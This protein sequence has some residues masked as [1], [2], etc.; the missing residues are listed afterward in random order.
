MRPTSVVVSKISKHSS[1]A[2]LLALLRAEGLEDAC[3]FIY[4]PVGFRDG[5]VCGY[6]FLNFISHEIA[7]A[8][9][10]A[11]DR[12]MPPVAEVGGE[13]LEVEWA[14]GNQG[15]ESLVNR[16]RNSPVLLP[17][18]PEEWQPLLFSEGRR[19]PFPAPTRNVKAVP[20]LQSKSLTGAE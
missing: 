13:P 4:L 9:F 12:Q 14:K 16:Y 2:A 5:L 18:V 17:G 3:D 1:R 15:L 19:V 6:A 8:A 20:H 10:E 11:L 7:V